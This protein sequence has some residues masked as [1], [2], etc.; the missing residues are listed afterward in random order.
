MAGRNFYDFVVDLLVGDPDKK[1]RKVQLEREQLDLAI[2]RKQAALYEEV[3]VEAARRGWP[4]VPTLTPDG[5]IVLQPI[6]PQDN[7]RQVVITD[8]S[9]NNSGPIRM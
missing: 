5:K 6:V 8:G 4:I 7:S 1:L 2:Q 3:L 9:V